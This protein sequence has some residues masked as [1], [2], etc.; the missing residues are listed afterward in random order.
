MNELNTTD[1]NQPKRRFGLWG[2]LLAI[3]V[4]I[5]TLGAIAHAGP[6]HFGPFAGMHGGFS[7]ERASKH[8][9]KMVNWALE[10]VDATPEQKTQVNDIFQQAMKE[11][12]PVHQQVHDAH[13]QM[14]QLMSQPVI[15]RAAIEQLRI[16]QVAVLD[17]ASKRLT[18]AFE[19]AGEVLS[20]E[21]RQK[22]IAMHHHVMAEHA[23][24]KD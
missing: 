17:S 4:G 16:A 7:P 10:D 9:K 15:D 8:V 21:Q 13:E 23:R 12:L 1:T 24:S 22:L 5:A 11:L 6:G 14:M 19:D 20:P 2:G 3:V 18:Q